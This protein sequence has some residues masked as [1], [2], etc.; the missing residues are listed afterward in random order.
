ML[1]EN[2]NDG[3]HYPRTYSHRSSTDLC[4]LH[5]SLNTIPPHIKGLIALT[6]IKA[7]LMRAPLGLRLCLWLVTRKRHLAAKRLVRYSDIL[8]K[9]NKEVLETLWNSTMKHMVAGK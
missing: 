8:F 2:E 9:K 5:A 1:A 7:N 6:A 4:D 3:A